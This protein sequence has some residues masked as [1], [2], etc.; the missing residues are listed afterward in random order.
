MVALTSTGKVLTWGQN[1]N[2]QLGAGITAT[3]PVPH[4]V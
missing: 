1:S 2:G 4:P 3:T